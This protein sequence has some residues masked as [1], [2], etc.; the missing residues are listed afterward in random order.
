MSKSEEAKIYKKADAVLKNKHPTEL[1]SGQPSSSGARAGRGGRHAA[2]S[3]YVSR[4][5][6][7]PNLIN[8]SPQ[9]GLFDKERCLVKIEPSCCPLVSLGPLRMLA[10][11]VETVNVDPYEFVIDHEAFQIFERTNGSHADL[12]EQTGLLLSF[13]RCGGIILAALHRPALRH[14]PPFRFSGCDKA[15]LWACVVPANWQSCDLP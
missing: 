2:P 14:H 7:L 13:D 3:L 15:D 8:D 11:H 5:G 1:W 9:P 10:L 12:T 6:K 4:S